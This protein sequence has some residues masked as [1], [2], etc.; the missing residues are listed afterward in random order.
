MAEPAD[1][2]NQLSNRN[3]PVQQGSVSIRE[4][5]MLLQNQNLGSITVYHIMIIMARITTIISVVAFIVAVA[6]LIKWS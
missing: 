4:K 2:D 3:Y 5:R 6:A 1:S